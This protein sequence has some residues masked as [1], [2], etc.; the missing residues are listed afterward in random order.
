MNER[1][2]EPLRWWCVNVNGTELL[3]NCKFV[4]R[5]YS[6]VRAVARITS[7]TAACVP[8]CRMPSSVSML[9]D[10]A[11]DVGEVQY[12][13]ESGG[14]TRVSELPPLPT[15][16]Y[17]T[18][19]SQAASG[20]LVVFVMS[21][22]MVGMPHVSLGGKE[23]PFD[24]PFGS[25]WIGF[26]L[27]YLE[28]SLA[29][30]CLLGLLWGDP[31]VLKRSQERCFPL[32]AAVLDKLAMRESLAGMENVYEGGH[33]FCVRCCIWRPDAPPPT[34]RDTVHHC[35]VCNRCVADFDHHCGVFGR[36]IAGRGWRGNMGFFKGILLCAF[37]GVVTCIFTVATTAVNGL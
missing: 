14:P 23:G 35:S 16:N 19:R 3:Y 24:G 21:C 30:C 26:I 20:M 5:F 7:V 34:Y 32:P 13:V 27:L 17:S 15:P 25:K 6:K 1:M 4:T 10:D 2:N 9:A 33:T 11:R 28:A 8:I 18:M 12:S 22:A 31:G 36:C 29:F 37:A